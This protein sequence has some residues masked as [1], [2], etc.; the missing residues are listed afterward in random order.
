[1]AWGLYREMSLEVPRPADCELVE[2][3]TQLVPAVL[4]AIAGRL[5][6]SHWESATAWHEGYSR[7]SWQGVQLLMGCKEDL[8]IE[9]RGIRDGTPGHAP[10]DLST[11][12][13]GMYPGSSLAELGNLLYAAP[14]SAA[15]LLTEIRDLLA[16][17][18]EGSA[19]QLELLGQIVL[20]L[21]A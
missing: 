20:L 12:P 7:L 1:M 15:E 18:G 17:S 13:P 11:Y 2:L 10:Y 6:P 8:I 5:G 19:E 9:I 16:A 3:D 14:N 4:S 21:G